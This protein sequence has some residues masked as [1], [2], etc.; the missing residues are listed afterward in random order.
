MSPSQKA[1]DH[2]QRLARARL[3]L[4]GL[5]VGDAFGERFFG[6]PG[7]A[8]RRI[9]AREV[10]MAPWRWTDDTAMA[11]SIVDV[12]AEHG[13]VDQDALSDTFTARYRA[14]PWRGYG[15][16]ARR[17]LQR[18]DAGAH[19][20]VVAPSLFE[21]N[22]S[23]GNGAAMR[24]API[25]AY[26]ADDQERAAAEASLSAVVTHSHPEAKAG[27]VAVAVATALAWQHRG[28][29]LDQ[30]REA[31]FEGTLQICPPSK[32]RE[33]I[34]EARQLSSE[35]AAHE[36]AGKLGSGDDVSSQDTVPFCLWAAMRHPSSFEDAMWAT[37]SGLGDRDTT[38]AIVGGVVALSATDGVPATWLEA[39]EALSAPPR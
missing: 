20:S 14:E 24:V 25:G 31:V 35:V 4:D 21:G 6:P 37:V 34:E 11:L 2:S 32:T 10:P 18:V 5:S 7:E 39:R 19:W 36:V 15:G 12:L 38:C 30:L 17:L 3:S 8:I 23:Y 28:A 9:V 16:G 1:A 22:G 27:A 26:F 29:P 33:G 13:R